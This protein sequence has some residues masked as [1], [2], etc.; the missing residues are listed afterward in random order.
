MVFS[1]QENPFEK[2]VA[3]LDSSTRPFTTVS[4]RAQI[5]EILSSVYDSL[6]LK[7]YNPINQLVGYILTE[8]PTYITNYN[9]ARSLICRVD[10][11]ELLQ[12]LVRTYLEKP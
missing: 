9:N 6:V 10:R 2:E 11:D 8:D 7:G 12:E 4:N 5:R 1:H 3:V